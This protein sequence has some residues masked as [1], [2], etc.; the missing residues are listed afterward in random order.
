MI[1][2]Q[3]R[4]NDITPS[5]MNGELRN[6][7]QVYWGRTPGQ[8]PRFIKMG[9]TCLAHGTEVGNTIF[10]LICVQHAKQNWTME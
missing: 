7:V 9:T 6:E 10:D 8:W 4:T 1:I 2:E 3:E 5:V